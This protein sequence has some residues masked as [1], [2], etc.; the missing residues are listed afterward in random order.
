MPVT[1]LSGAVI[2]MLL[3]C[4]SVEWP[5]TQQVYASNTRIRVTVRCRSQATL[6]LRRSQII[7]QPHRAEYSRSIAP[8]GN[9]IEV[10]DV[11]GTEFVREHP[12]FDSS[13]VFADELLI[14]EPFISRHW[15]Q[16]TKAI[17]RFVE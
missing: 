15:F 3:L 9:A 17:D 11:L 13:K 8:I 12:L 10:P 16:M 5:H 2:K 6:D 14:T 7:Q 1:M 4:G